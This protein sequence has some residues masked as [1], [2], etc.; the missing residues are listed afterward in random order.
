MISC[1]IFSLPCDVCHEP[2]LVNH[3][4]SEAERSK[5]T[6]VLFLLSFLFF[7]FF[8]AVALLDII[9]ALFSLRELWVPVL[10]V[11]FKEQ[12]L[13]QERCV[14]SRL[15]RKQQSRRFCFRFAPFS[16]ADVRERALVKTGSG[17]RSRGGKL[18]QKRAT[19]LS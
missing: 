12:D 17:Q 4:H 3:R 14:V 9:G 15:K 1:E 2:V 8:Q 6:P 7:S 13:E 16:D 5:Q 19:T 18:T 10:K 11:C